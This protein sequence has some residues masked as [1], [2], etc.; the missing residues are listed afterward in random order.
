[1]DNLQIRKINKKEDLIRVS[2]IEKNSFEYCY[3]FSLLYSLYNS[4]PDGFMVAENKKTNY[5]VGY[6]IATIEWGNGHIVSIATDSKHRNEGVG[7]ILLSSMEDY[8]FKKYGVNN[9]ILEVRFDNVNARKFYYKRGYV[10]KRLV[11][12]YYDDG[13]D[14]ILMVKKNPNIINNDPIIVNMW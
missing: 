6:I 4:F 9:I 8:L 3:P 7:G 1:M 5:I 2:E 11:K 12:D 13:A 14:A 10:D